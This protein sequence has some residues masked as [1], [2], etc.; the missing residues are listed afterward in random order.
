LQQLVRHARFLF[1]STAVV[2]AALAGEAT[3]EAG[4]S[5]SVASSVAAPAGAS[6][7]PPW[8]QKMVGSSA[9]LGT[10][11][12]S[13]T[14]YSSGYHDPYVSTSL[15]LRP[16]YDLGTRFKLAV[17]ARLYAEEELTQPDNPEG[18]HFTPYDGWLSL[19]AKDL[20][21][22]E[23]SK[24]VVGGVLRVILPLSYESRWANLVAGLVGGATLGRDF[25]FGSDP[26]PER[27][28]KLSVTLIELYTKYLHTIDFH[29]NPPGASTGCRGFVAAG[30]VA[31][32]AEGASVAASDRC[33][34][35]YNFDFGLRTAGTISLT[36][37]KWALGLTLL[38]DNTFLYDVPANQFTADQTVNRG[39]EDFTWGILSLTYSLTDH[40][41][42]NAGISSLQPALDAQSKNLRF[43]F[44]DFSGATANNY[45]QAFVSLTGTL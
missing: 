12:G 8:L 34:G 11:V 25:E 5:D 45:T 37:G 23:T 33:G 39:R 7:L 10:Y 21:T 31:A 13:G 30:A 17:T 36:R 18:R 41:A 43:P 15:Y 6:T 16:T 4:P 2:L 38:V 24:L 29:G 35:P 19:V 44:F 3:S 28:F 22:F 32:S 27:R 9:E 42:V 1:V 14:F 40:F 26:A 20:H